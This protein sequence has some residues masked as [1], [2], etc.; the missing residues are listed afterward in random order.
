MNDEQNEP[1]DRSEAD[2][3]SNKKS[4]GTGGTKESNDAVVQL[5]NDYYAVD[6]PKKDV[7]STIGDGEMRD[8]GLVGAGETTTGIQSYSDSMS[9][10][11]DLAESQDSE[12]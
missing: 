10:E 12:Q 8:E 2:I 11:Q 5:K 4:V 7:L 9:D 1:E 6:Y 3:A